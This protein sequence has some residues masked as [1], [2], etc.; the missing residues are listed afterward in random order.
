MNFIC[1]PTSKQSQAKSQA[2]TIRPLKTDD[3]SA[4]R[5]KLSLLGSRCTLSTLYY[6]RPSIVFFLL[7]L[8]SLLLLPFLLFLR[9]NSSRLG[10][11]RPF[12]QFLEQ[13]E[14]CSVLFELG[15]EATVRVN[16]GP[17]RPHQVDSLLDSQ[18]IL[19]DQIR[20][21]TSGGAAHSLPAVHKHAISFLFSQRRAYELVHCPEVL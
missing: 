12:L 1:T 3:F 10:N 19:R 13:F 9:N 17:A 6:H 20:H 18:A 8:Y 7:L 5:T 14:L 21:Q 2:A 11:W 15:N 4:T 16:F